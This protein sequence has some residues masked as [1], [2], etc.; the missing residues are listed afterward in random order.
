M[1]SC[2]EADRRL[3]QLQSRLLHLQH[4]RLHTRRTRRSDLPNIRPYRQSTSATVVFHQRDV[5]HLTEVDVAHF[6][7]IHTSRHARQ[8]RKLRAPELLDAE[9]QANTVPHDLTAPVLQLDSTKISHLATGLLPQT[10][11]DDVAQPLTNRV[12]DGDQ[13]QSIQESG[14]TTETREGT[15]IVQEVR[16]VA[17][18]DLHPQLR[19]HD[20]ATSRTN[21]IATLVTLVTT[22]TTSLSVVV[23]NWPETHHA[24]GHI[25]LPISYLLWHLANV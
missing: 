13:R 24:I 23:R 22:A 18:N 21:I 11:T 4:P 19:A 7:E 2:K 3:L 6:R 25:H 16:T 20:T 8:K 1:L 10:V 14:N 9:S 12:G 5:V 17:E 15:N